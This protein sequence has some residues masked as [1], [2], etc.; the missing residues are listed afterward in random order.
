MNDKYLN[1]LKEIGA[2]CDHGT[3]YLTGINIKKFADLI[4]QECA[5]AIRTDLK[6]CPS[7]LNWKCAMEESAKVVERHFGV[8]E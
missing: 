6:K 1:A 5:E 4:V 7:D 3:P 2:E 8:E